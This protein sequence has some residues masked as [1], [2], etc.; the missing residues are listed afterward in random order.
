M[1][2][3]FGVLGLVYLVGSRDYLG[4]SLPLIAKAAAGFPGGEVTPAPATSP[5]IGSPRRTARHAAAVPERV[6][7]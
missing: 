4:L 3:G 6:H 2:G 7:G 5:G 1:I